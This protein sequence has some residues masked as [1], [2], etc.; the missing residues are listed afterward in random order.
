[1][2][3]GAIPVLITLGI[4]M[5]LFYILRRRGGSVRQ[6]PEVVQGLVFE[7]RLNQALVDTFHLREKPKRFESTNW[8]IHKDK[9]DFLEESL[10]NTL[11][12]VFEMVEYFNQQIKTAKKAKAF[13]RLSLDVSKLKEP[14]AESKKGL[15]DWLE[16]NTGHRELP[17]KYPSLLGSLFGER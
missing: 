10:Q 14:L 4:V 3:L 7:V 2:D 17:P 11:S 6:R 5:L 8:Q 13:D 16:E 1:M 9:L 15:E 12:G